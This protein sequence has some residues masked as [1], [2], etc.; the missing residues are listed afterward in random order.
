MDVG[1]SSYKQV[2]LLDH[3][4]GARKEGV[5]CFINLCHPHRAAVDGSFVIIGHC[6]KVVCM[7]A[8]MHATSTGQHCMHSMVS[9]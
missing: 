8:C 5:K 4:L 6:A 3:G 1:K 2:G 7:H 9:L